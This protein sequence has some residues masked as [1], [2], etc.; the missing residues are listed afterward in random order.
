MST[1]LETTDELEISDKGLKL[2]RAKW[3]FLLEEAGPQHM[4]TMAEAYSILRQMEREDSMKDHKD[5]FQKLA[6][7]VR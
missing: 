6:N 3:E 7:S 5:P 2:F 4:K 1:E